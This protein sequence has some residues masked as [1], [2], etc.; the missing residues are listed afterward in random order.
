MRTASAVALAILP[1]APSDSKPDSVEELGDR[2]ATLAAHLH[3]AEYRLLELIREFD[4]RDGWGGMGFRTCAQWLSWRTGISPGPARERVRVAKAL[5]QLPLIGDAMRRGRLSYSKVRAITRVATPETEAD[6]LDLALTGTAAHV[7]RLVRTWKQVDR[8]QEACDERARHERRHLEMWTEDSG[9]V[10]ISGSLDPEVGALLRRALEAAGDAM[11]K[12]ASTA[13]ETCDAP[14]AT[15]PHATASQRRA[16]ALGLL[17]EWALAGRG[18][19]ARADRFQVMVSVE[20]SELAADAPSGGAT[21]NGDLRVPAGTFRRLACDASRVV[22]VHDADG[23]EV[24]VGRR[25]RTVPSA[26]RRALRRRDTGCRFPGC[27]AHFADAHHI[28][29]WAEGGET[30]LDNLVLLCRTHHRAV[31][32]GGFTVSSVAAGEFEFRR[33]DG[34]TF[35]DVPDIESVDDGWNGECAEGWDHTRNGVTIHPQT[36]ASA[37]AG[38]RFDVGFALDGLRR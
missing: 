10:R 26:I 38:E 18:E 27:S 23:S 20:A 34:P 13:A 6:L 29:H 28:R 21:L 36:A 15:A 2:I 8:L 11:F 1:N 14:Q 32:E 24:S 5:A 22:V 19:P 12:R 33:P 17:A 7:E 37:W 3:A 16:D 31:H 9:A 30:T 25:S 4:E 35:P